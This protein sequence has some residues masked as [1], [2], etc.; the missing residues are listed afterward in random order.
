M[1][2]RL[3]RLH[4]CNEASRI[5]TYFL[6]AKMAQDDASR[7]SGEAPRRRRLGWG[8]GLVKL[9][10]APSE[11]VTSPSVPAAAT[12]ALAAELLHSRVRRRRSTTMWIMPHP[13]VFEQVQQE[14]FTVIDAVA[15][16]ESLRLPCSH[17]YAALCS[18]CWVRLWEAQGA[19]G[20]ASVCAQSHHW[21]QLRL[22]NLVCMSPSNVLLLRSDRLSSPRMLL[23]PSIHP[24]Q[25][26]SNRRGT[27]RTTTA[28]SCRPTCAPSRPHRRQPR[29]LSPSQPLRWICGITRAP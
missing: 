6:S 27:P 25:P 7:A 2:A 4:V 12:E 13:V 22:T 11:D 23:L 20:I 3:A 19:T 5:V 8:Q 15:G 16:Q 9:R 14:Y 18:H 17:A 24:Q 28:A 26:S 1:T 29:P 21:V 10:S